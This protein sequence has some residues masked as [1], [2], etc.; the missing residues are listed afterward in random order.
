MVSRP[1]EEIWKDVISVLEEKLQYGLL[2]QLKNISS[3]DI[4]GSQ[5]KLIVTDPES[6]EF[7][8]SETNQQRLIILCRPVLH[9]EEILIELKEE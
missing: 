7:L 6:F 8:T 2:Q 5:L 9:V 1:T 4:A 3:L